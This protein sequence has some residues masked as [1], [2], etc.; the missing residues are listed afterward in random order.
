MVYFYL[1]NN[2]DMKIT[3]PSIKEIK[4]IIPV[5][6]NYQKHI[7]F[8]LRLISIF[9][10]IICLARPQIYNTFRQVISSGIDIMLTL[11][12]SGSMETPDFTYNGVQV[13]RLNIVKLVVQEFI[14]K[15][16]GDRI[17]MV[18]F[19][20]EAFTQCPITLDHNILSDL[21]KDL[22][23]GMAGEATGMGT[24][25]GIAVK[26]LKDIN[27]K[28]KIIILLTDGRNNAG[29]IAPLTA[30]ELAKTYGIKIYT[31]GVGSDNLQN[32][33]VSQMI[34]GY[35]LSQMTLDEDTLKKI[36]NI[37][38]GQYFK[39]TDTEML[40]K[41]YNTINQLEKSKMKIK[42]YGKINEL[43]IYLLPIAIIIFLLEII[44]SNTIL[45]KIP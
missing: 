14:N 29:Q 32:L 43:Y 8:I 2:S 20:T 10:I 40:Q 42:E 35:D 3:F 38:G 34:K 18:V 1:K 26:R 19:G 13:S 9:L 21:L 4:D 45:A 11:D 15:R 44:L 6:Y 28:S 22:Q 33:S 30:A 7:T 16:P 5:K 37:T 12:T 23:I 17:G 39:A 41:I 36:A 25:I 24:A 27:A 31:I